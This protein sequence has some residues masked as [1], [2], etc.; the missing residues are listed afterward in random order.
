DRTMFIIN[1]TNTGGTVTSYINITVVSNNPIIAYI[2]DDISLLSN[3]TVLDLS[4]I[5]TG[6]IVTER[7]ISPEVS[8]GL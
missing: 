4:P 3:S 2:P 7:S 8:P 5:S 1:G 6:G